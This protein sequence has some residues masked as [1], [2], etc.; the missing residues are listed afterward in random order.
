MATYSVENFRQTVLNTGLARKNRFECEIA[1]PPQV[2]QATNISEPM[3]SLYVESAVF[4]E[5]T[6]NAETQFIWGPL[7]HRPKTLSYGGFMVLQF[8]LDEDM[9]IKRTFDYW[10]QSI[11]DGEQY[12]VSYQRDY[13]A[14]LMRITQL[15]KNDQPTYIV[16]LTDVFPAGVV[17]LDV[18]HSLQNAVHLLQVSFRFRKWESLAFDPEF[19]FNAVSTKA[20][21]NNLEKNGGAFT[22]N[23][24]LEKNTIANRPVEPRTVVGG[25]IFKLPPKP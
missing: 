24:S 9:A 11:V 15:D 25:H 23:N 20:G 3:L 12:T 10:L 18:N 14:P 13:V 19:G 5:L 21:I 17:Q 16:N 6:I 2:R 8:Y 22:R 4:P 1:V 7:I